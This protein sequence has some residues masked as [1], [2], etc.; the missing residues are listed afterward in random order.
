MKFTQ[1]SRERKIAITLTENPNAKRSE[2]LPFLEQARSIVKEMSLFESTLA[3]DDINWSLFED[4]SL[5]ED[6][7]DDLNEAAGDKLESLKTSRNP[8][9]RMFRW[10][11]TILAKG[12]ISNVYKK[13]IMMFAKIM[14]NDVKV[15]LKKDQVGAGGSGPETKA[16]MIEL[17]GM[18]E[19]SKLQQEKV[20]QELKNAVD[21][22]RDPGFFK[23]GGIFGLNGD[24]LD[25]HV[26]LKNIEMKLLLNE[27]KIKAAQKVLTPAAMEKL[28]T[29]VKQLK[30]REAKYAAELK[31]T[32]DAVKNAIEKDDFTGA[33]A[34]IK[35]QAEALDQ[36]IAKADEDIEA[37]REKMATSVD[38]AGGQEDYAKNITALEKQRKGYMKERQ[39]LMKKAKKVVLGDTKS[40]D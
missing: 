36:K 12:K 32:E 9:A 5:L 18:L 2:W 4:E 20:Q 34:D 31:S 37:Y 8:L 19:R 25:K 21:K 26:A 16:K 23:A 15:E 14:Q 39:G 40:E 38:D 22:I 24:V 35:V 17:N 27:A 6:E 28:K 33:D 3:Q 7:D 30:A 13:F 10:K 1:F 11:S 29:E